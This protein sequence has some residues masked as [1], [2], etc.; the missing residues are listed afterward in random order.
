MIVRWEWSVLPQ[1]PIQVAVLN[2][3]DPVPLE[4]GRQGVRLAWKAQRRS[5]T[6]NI[7]RAVCAQDDP[8]DLTMIG[9]INFSK[10]C[11]PSFYIEWPRPHS[12]V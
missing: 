1:V 11:G 5:A 4:W 9:G 2:H 12:W 10:G 6:L 8:S 7:L 3:L